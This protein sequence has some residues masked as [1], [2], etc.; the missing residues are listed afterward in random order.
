MVTSTGHITW[1]KMG[2]GGLQLETISQI[3]N[4]GGLAIVEYHSWH[5]GDPDRGSHYILGTL[6]YQPLFTD[7]GGRHYK[8]VGQTKG[9]DPSAYDI[10]NIVVRGFYLK[11][12]SYPHGLDPVFYYLGMVHEERM[13][14]GGKLDELL[15]EDTDPALRILRIGVLNP[16]NGIE[17]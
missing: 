1:Y 10:K 2:G 6:V 14:F 12:L 4:N 17:R 7:I 16:D 11:T 15:D 8:V 9:F 13:R 5:H 3:I